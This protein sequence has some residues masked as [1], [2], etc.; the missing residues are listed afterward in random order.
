MSCKFYKI[1][2]E[3]VVSHFVASN[4]GRMPEDPNMTFVHGTEIKCLPATDASSSFHQLF[5]FCLP[6]QRTLMGF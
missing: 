3:I 6:S 1:C 5:I 2:L 4:C